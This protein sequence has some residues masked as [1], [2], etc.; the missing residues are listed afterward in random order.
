MAGNECW[1]GVELSMR[2]T[3]GS[4]LNVCLLFFD[5]MGG[6]RRLGRSR[7]FALANCQAHAWYRVVCELP[8]V[9]LRVCCGGDE[10]IS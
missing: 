5:E 3:N 4:F 2:Q 7:R 6:V 9:M 10:A 1:L 8:S